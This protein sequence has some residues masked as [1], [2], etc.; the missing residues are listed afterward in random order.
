MVDLSVAIDFN[1]DF[2]T[3][4][5]IEGSDNLGEAAFAKDF[6]HLKAVKNV[7]FR[8][9]DKI[10]L[11]VVLTTFPARYHTLSRNDIARIVHSVIGQFKHLQ[12]L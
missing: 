8:L 6:K 9:Q 12:F 7:V 2:L 1:G 4:E 11:F 10:M 5:V 3:G